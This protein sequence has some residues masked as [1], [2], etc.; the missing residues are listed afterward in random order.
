MNLNWPWIVVI[1]TNV[2]FYNCTNRII[3]RRK[4]WKFLI[5]SRLFHFLFFFF[6]FHVENTQF[7]NLDDQNESRSEIG[8]MNES[9]NGGFSRDG[10][11][12]SFPGTLS[13]HAPS[14]RKPGPTRLNSRHL[15]ENSIVSRHA[16]QEE[17]RFSWFIGSCRREFGNV[18]PQNVTSI[19]CLRI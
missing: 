13:L 5:Q 1:W 19:D 15:R 18:A 7:Y 9:E 2:E 11:G 16:S 14:D 6:L 3:L 8:Q 10:G 12:Q 4:T 17:T